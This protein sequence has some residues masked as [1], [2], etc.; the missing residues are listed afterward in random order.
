MV[1]RNSAFFQQADK[2]L[3]R[4]SEKVCR[5]LGGKRLI[6]VHQKDGLLLTHGLNH[7]DK[8]VIEYLGKFDDIARGGE[9]YRPNV[10]KQHSLQPGLLFGGDVGRPNSFLV[11]SAHTLVMT[12]EHYIC[13]Q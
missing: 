11:V 7:R 5:G 6:F 9:E 8:Q 13:N 10:P 4:Y 12:P 2:I 1:I 3:P